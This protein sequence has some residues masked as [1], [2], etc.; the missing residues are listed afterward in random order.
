MEDDGF[1]NMLKSFLAGFTRCHTA[2]QVG[3][4]GAVIVIRFLN[5]DRIRQFI[6][7]SSLSKWVSFLGDEYRDAQYAID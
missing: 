3:H 4:V 1:R 7:G 2:G 6:I 5:H